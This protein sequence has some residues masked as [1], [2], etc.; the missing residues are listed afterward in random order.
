MNE[1]KKL[2]V[3]YDSPRSWSIYIGTVKNEAKMDLA[4]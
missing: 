1:K 2:T 4:S 3:K